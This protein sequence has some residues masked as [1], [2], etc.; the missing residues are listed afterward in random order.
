[1]AAT[2]TTSAVASAFEAR[3]AAV[4]LRLEPFITQGAL[5]SLS[6]YNTTVG[7]YSLKRL[8][9]QYSGAQIKVRRSTDNVEA[10]L[11]YNSTG[12]LYKLQTSTETILLPTLNLDTWKGA[13]ELFVP[14]WYDQS[15]GGKHL[16]QTNTTLQPKLVYDSQSWTVF[17]FGTQ[18]MAAP[19]LFASTTVSTAHFLART[20][21]IGRTECRLFAFNTESDFINTSRLQL[22]LPWVSG[23]YTILAGPNAATNGRRVDMSPSEANVATNSISSC[24]AWMTTQAVSLTIVNSSGQAFTKTT[25]LTATVTGVDGF[26][27]GRSP[28][29]PTTQSSNHR[30]YSF[31]ALN[32]KTS[33]TNTTAV[34]AVL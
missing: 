31:I 27:L 9:N 22:H 34:L 30:V 19:N 23:T 29:A 25:T 24:S 26:W 3:Y 13:G 8:F 10:D 33:D 32:A 17:V 12:V 14:T 21:E 7:A 4:K 20:Q 2:W 15:A 6:I 28:S 1:M 5:D 11:W 16:Q 18:S